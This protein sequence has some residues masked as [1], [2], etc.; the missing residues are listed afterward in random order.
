MMR[1]IT[2]QA[3]GVRLKTPEGEHTRPTAERTKE[4]IFSMLQFDLY[5]ANVLDLFA[6]SGQMALEAL[7]R[8]A[9]YAVLCDSSREAVEVIRDN[10]TKTRL[11]DR[12]RVLGGDCFS[13]LQ[14]VKNRKFDLVFLDPPYAEGLIPRALRALL[15]ADLLADGAKLVCEAASFE[16]VFSN[17][18]ALAT[19]FEILKQTHYGIAYVTVLQYN[20]NDKKES[21]I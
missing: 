21:M 17:D 13:A 15:A 8:G 16:D 5:R 10:A 11:S 20:T 19:H 9:E 3:R 7:S 1:I 2:G 4:A 14:A 6:G 12:C 18:P